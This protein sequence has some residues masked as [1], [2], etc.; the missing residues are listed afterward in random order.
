MRLNRGGR[1]WEFGF[2]PNRK[3]NAGGR[4]EMRQNSAAV[5][6]WEP[7]WLELISTFGADRSRLLKCSHKGT[8]LRRFAILSVYRGAG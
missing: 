2:M 1:L 8:S 3:S 5:R 6:S 7:A 4:A